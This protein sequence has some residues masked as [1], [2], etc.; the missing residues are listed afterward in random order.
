MV[1]KLTTVEDLFKD[2]GFVTIY[3]DP[4]GNIYGANCVPVKTNGYWKDSEF[5]TLLTELFDIP[6]LDE[7]NWEKSLQYGL[8]EP[9]KENFKLDAKVFVR[10]DSSQPWLT[11]HLA[12][13]SEDVQGRPFGVWAEGKTSFTLESDPEFIF[14]YQYCKYAPEEL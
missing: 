8:I 3:K 1:K 6:E 10:N 5:D 11:A 14:C 2:F 13:L 4:K 12:S 9:T 7:V